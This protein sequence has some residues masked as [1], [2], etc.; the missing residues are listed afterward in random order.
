MNDSSR[1]GSVVCCLVAERSAKGLDFPA[2]NDQSPD[3][4]IY[5]T[6]PVPLASWRAR[7]GER[8]HVPGQVSKQRES[9]K[10][11]IDTQVPE[12]DIQSNFTA[13]REDGNLENSTAS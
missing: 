6:V 9:K 1:P 8:L 13:H 11:L 5:S 4:D 2:G 12:D 3:H 7:H 10:A